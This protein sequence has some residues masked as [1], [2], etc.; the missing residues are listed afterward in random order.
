[1]KSK[2]TFKHESIL[3][4]IN[5]Q[6]LLDAIGKSF[7]KGSLTFADEDGAPLVIEPKDQLRVKVTAS[8]EFGKEQVEIKVKWD[9]SPKKVDSQPPK[10]S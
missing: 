9:H 4:A 5:V 10:V 7:K 2:T 6:S 8:K 1:M 3:D